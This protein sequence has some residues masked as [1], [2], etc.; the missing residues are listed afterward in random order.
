MQIFYKTIIERQGDHEN[1]CLETLVLSAA[2]IVYGEADCEWTISYFN[3]RRFSLG[4]LGNVSD[5]GNAN[6]SVTWKYNFAS[7][8]LL[9]DYFNSFNSYINGELHRNQIGGVAS[10]QVKKENEKFTVVCSR[11][12]QNLE[13]GHFTLLFCREQQK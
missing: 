5:D 10:V 8:V 9:R 7:S 11:S 12:P 4:T 6:E 1:V 3:G 13:F 2:Y